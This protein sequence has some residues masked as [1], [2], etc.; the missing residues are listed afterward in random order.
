M[1]CT[2]FSYNFNHFL[3]FNN[4]GLGATMSP[5]SHQLTILNNMLRLSKVAPFV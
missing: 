1:F 3:T 5:N 2:I 4:Y